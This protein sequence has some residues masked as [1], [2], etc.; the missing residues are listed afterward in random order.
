MQ[1]L[2]ADAKRLQGDD[3]NLKAFHDEFMARGRLPMSVI[4]WEMTGLDDEVKELWESDPL[5]R[6]RR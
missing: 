2:L 3:F 1:H 5:P 6:G 4:R